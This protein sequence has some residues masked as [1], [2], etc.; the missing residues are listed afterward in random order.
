MDPSV[1]S[2]IPDTIRFTETNLREALRIAEAEDNIELVDDV[3]EIIR[4]GW[5]YSEVDLREDLGEEDFEVLED[6][7]AFLADGWT[8]TEA[9]LREYLVREDLGDEDDIE[10]F[11]D[12]RGYFD[13]ARTLRLLMYLPALLVLIVVGFLGG[14]S[15]SGRFAWA[16]GSLAVTSAIIFVAFGPVYSAVSESPLEDARE[17]AISEIDVSGDFYSTERLFIGK[18]FDIGELVIDGFGSGVS[19][20]ALVLLIVGLV[21]LG[22]AL[23]WADVVGV[24]RR[25]RQRVMQANA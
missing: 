11:D 3:R 20:K 19:T 13:L 5:S 10:V 14:R 18:L 7:R 22:A 2:A 8:Y 17:E 21:G 24:V 12:M 25:V 1:L 9:D 23:R 15:W 4:D 16:A 6:V